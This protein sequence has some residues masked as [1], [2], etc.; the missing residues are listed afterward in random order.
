MDDP[1]NFVG[2]HWPTVRRR[3][4]GLSMVMDGQEMVH[5][6]E[7]SPGHVFL[8]TGAATT[9][10]L[11]HFARGRAGEASSGR[12]RDSSGAMAGTH[13]SDVTGHSLSHSLSNSVSNSLSN[14]YP[15]PHPHLDVDSHPP[16]R[17]HQNAHTFRHHRTSS[18]FPAQSPPVPSF[19]E[20]SAAARTGATA[21]ASALAKARAKA[22]FHPAPCYHACPQGWTGGPNDE[23]MGGPFGPDPAFSRGKSMFRHGDLQGGFSGR[24]GKF[25]N[26]HNEPYGGP[27]G[28]DPYYVYENAGRAST[29][30]NFPPARNMYPSV[31]GVGLGSPGQRGGG[32]ARAGG[33]LR[34]HGIY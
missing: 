16:H 9:A 6:A 14:S 10:G 26:F 32:M 20:L 7:G 17:R 25:R 4:S 31:R 33:T 27:F 2:Q 18:T 19:I 21:R 24:G 15:H 1:K 34:N 29:L 22:M 5:L 28:A 11:R 12:G 13:A 30:N 8:E 23:S 3:Y